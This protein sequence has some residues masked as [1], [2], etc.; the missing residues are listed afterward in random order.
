M[1]VF[2]SSEV[3]RKMTKN[4]QKAAFAFGQHECAAGPADKVCHFNCGPVRFTTEF[5]PVQ[6]GMVCVVKMA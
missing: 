5:C 2:I 4:D 6:G 1:N 3:T